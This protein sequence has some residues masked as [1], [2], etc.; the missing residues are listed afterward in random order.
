MATH[1]AKQILLIDDDPAILMTVGDRLALEGYGVAKAASAREGLDAIARTP[2][3]LIILDISMPGVSGLAMLK[4]LTD[5]NGALRYPVLVLTA[6]ANMEEFFAQTNVDGFVAKAS[7][8]NQLLREVKRVLA[9]HGTRADGAPQPPAAERDGA[10]ALILVVED[11]PQKL[12]RIEDAFSE[13]GYL[14][15][16][17]RDPRTVVEVAL[18]RHPD[19]LLVKVILPHMNGTVVAGTLAELPNLARIPLILYDD[20]GLHQQ[21][22]AHRNVK[23]FV[24]SSSP[25]LL[26]RQATALLKA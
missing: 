23:A 25:A 17:V 26:L 9:K 6:R 3:D 13:A 11:D 10:S 24:T 21:D 12:R 19:L 16:G 5:A 8:P 22:S 14:V 4:D 1:A 20:T 18:Q 7:D 15:L 2:P